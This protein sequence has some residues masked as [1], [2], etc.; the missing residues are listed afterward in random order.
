MYQRFLGRVCPY[1]VCRDLGMVNFPYYLFSFD[2]LV[3]DIY[4]GLQAVILLL[5]L[6]I[7]APILFLC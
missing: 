5:H 1:A 7:F 4:L 6:P 3:A 2:F